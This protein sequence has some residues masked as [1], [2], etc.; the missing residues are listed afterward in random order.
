MELNWRVTNVAMRNTLRYAVCKDLVTKL[1][2]I[3]V[4]FIFKISLLLTIRKFKYGIDIATRNQ[5]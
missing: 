4:T 2:N 5:N 1:L 3:G